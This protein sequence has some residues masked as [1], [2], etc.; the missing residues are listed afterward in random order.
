MTK[1]E[2]VIELSK[3]FHD[4]KIKPIHQ[5]LWNRLLKEIE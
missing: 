4:K 5:E 1:E 2:L 3:I